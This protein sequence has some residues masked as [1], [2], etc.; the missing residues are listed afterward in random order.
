MVVDENRSGT[1]ILIPGNQTKFNYQ[2]KMKNVITYSK[3]FFVP[4][5]ILST[6]QYFTTNRY[7]YKNNVPGEL[8]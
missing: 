7:G 1:E 4:K 6:R 8:G 5:R 2:K 3:V